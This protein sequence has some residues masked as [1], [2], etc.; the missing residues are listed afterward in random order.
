MIIKIGRNGKDSQA[1]R[2]NHGRALRHRAGWKFI[3]IDLLERYLN[4]E[5]IANI[6]G[7]LENLCQRI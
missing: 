1:L 6:G 3:F 5:S 2:C 7:K 4:L